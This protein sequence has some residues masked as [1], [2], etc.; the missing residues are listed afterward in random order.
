MPIKHT[1]TLFTVPIGGRL[2]GEHNLGQKLIVAAI[3][4]VGAALLIIG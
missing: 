2:F 1:S 3:M 4:V